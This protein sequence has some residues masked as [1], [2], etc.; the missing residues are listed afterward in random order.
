LESD[1]A[2]FVTPTIGNFFDKLDALNE[3]GNYSPSMIGD[4]GSRNVEASC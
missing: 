4:L 1:R 2:K 3:T